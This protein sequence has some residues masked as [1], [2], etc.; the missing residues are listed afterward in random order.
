LL[1]A[2]GGVQ[3]VGNFEK[4]HAGIIPAMGRM[5]REYR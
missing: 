5:Q 3:V 2:E 1:V 4:R